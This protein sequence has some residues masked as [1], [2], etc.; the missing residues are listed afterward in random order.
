M[1]YASPDFEQ[2]LDAVALARRADPSAVV[3]G[4]FLRSAAKHAEERRGVSSPIDDI[5]AFR[6]YSAPEA[7]DILARCATH[8]YPRVPLRDA[9]RRLGHDAYPTLVETRGGRVLLALTGMKWQ[10][11]LQLIPQAY[12]LAGSARVVVRL[13][14]D[15]E[16]E[17]ELHNLWTFPDCYHV[18]VFEGAM[19][20]FKV[21]G[22]V[23]I[24][25]HADSRVDLRLTW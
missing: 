15:R 22:K 9:L 2:P 16:A 6:A 4:A 8:A 18:G 21:T 10:G 11:A 12:A 25:V 20:A 13:T 19:E 3:K 1:T 5:R 23:E 14:G 7:I 24:R 17:V